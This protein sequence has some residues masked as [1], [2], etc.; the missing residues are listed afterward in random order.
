MPG[1][2]PAWGNPRCCR[3]DRSRSGQ[4]QIRSELL[5]QFQQLVQANG[6]ETAR[7][8]ERGGAGQERRTPI[9]EELGT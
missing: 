2:N 1:G 6:W 3:Q 8:V 5:G 9:L 4:D 7:F